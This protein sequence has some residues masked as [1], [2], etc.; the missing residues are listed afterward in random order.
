MFLVPTSHSFKRKAYLHIRIA[1]LEE[2]EALEGLEEGLVE[3][4]VGHLRV[5][6][7]QGRDDVVHGLSNNNNRKFKGTLKGQ[8][9]NIRK[10]KGTLKGQ[11]HTKM[12]GKIRDILK[13]LAFSERQSGFLLRMLHCAMRNCLM[14]LKKPC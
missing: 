11:C 12:S 8:Y 5:V 10:F 2:Q 7:Q 4:E 13:V 14:L 1:E 9:N 3:V 6:V